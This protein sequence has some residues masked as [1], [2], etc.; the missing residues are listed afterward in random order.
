MSNFEHSSSCNSFT[1]T[2]KTHLSPSRLC[3]WNHSQ[4]WPMW[5]WF[6]PP[7]SSLCKYVALKLY[8]IC[9]ISHSSSL[10]FKKL[11]SSCRPHSLILNRDML[12]DCQLSGWMRSMSRSFW[13]FNLWHICLLLALFYRYTDFI[14]QIQKNP[15]ER[16]TCSEATIARSLCIPL[17][18]HSV[19]ST[20][21]WQKY[22][23]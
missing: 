12:C 17:Y 21:Y 4:L 20:G 2:W 11:S 19:H 16:L 18:I 22:W 6:V 7:L 9:L 5:T 1:S 15:S 8:C 13:P 3:H 23:R 10:S 14:L